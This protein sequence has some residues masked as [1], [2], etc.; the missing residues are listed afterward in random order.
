MRRNGESYTLIVPL[1]AVD[2]VTVIGEFGYGGSAQIT[3]YAIPDPPP[4]I[5]SPSEQTMQIT[6]D[7][8]RVIV[9]HMEKYGDELWG[10]VI[11]VA[12]DKGNITYI[13]AE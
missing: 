4:A 7:G 5:P 1:Y 8:Q 6:Y 10:H 12:D 9:Q 2:G 13:V 11:P 3:E